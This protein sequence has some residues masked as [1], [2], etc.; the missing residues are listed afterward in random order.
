MEKIKVLLKGPLLTQSG[1]GAHARMLFSALVDDPMFDLFCENTRWGH[2]SFVTDITKQIEGVNQCIMKREMQKQQA[3]KFVYDLFVHV[4]IP[5]EFEKLGK[6]NVGVT[7]AVETDRISHQWVEKSNE[8]DLVIVPSEHSKHVMVSTMIDWMNKQTGEKGTFKINKPVVVCPEGVDENVFK[9]VE[10]DEYENLL[11]L[12]F[13][14]E[15]NFLHVGQWGNGGFGED[16]KNISNLVKYFIETFAGRKDVG[17]VLKTN[18]ARN[19]PQDKEI[20]V[21]RLKQIKSLFPPAVVPPIYLVHGSLT[22]EEMASLYT[23][24]Q[25]KAY[26]SLAAGEGFGIPTLEAAMCG[27][28]VIATNWSGHL[29]FMNK[30]KFSAVKYELKEIPEIAVWDPVL[31]KGSRW[32]VVDEADA[33]HRLKMMASKYYNPKQWAK[34]LRE[35]IKDTFSLTAIKNVF[36]DTVKHYAINQNTSLDPI[37]WMDSFIDTPDDFN[38]LFTMPR[39]HGDVFVATA[40]LDGLMTEVPENTKIYFATDPKYF[41]ILEDNPHIHKVVQYQPFMIMTEATEEVFDL[42]LTPDVAT[43]Y[44]FSNWVRRGQGRNLAEEYANHCGCKVGNYSIK[45]DVSLVPSGK[46]YITIHAGSGEG[47]WSAR[48]Y[49][50]WPE[51]LSNLSAFYEDITVVQVGAADDMKLEGVLDLRGKTDVHQLAG[52]IKNAKLHLGIDSFPMHLAAG[53]DVPVV[54]LFGSSYANSTGPY[55][56]DKENS[57]FI[58]LETEN[59]MGCQKAC[60]K[61]E[62]KV[63]KEQSCLNNIDPHEVFQ[64]VTAIL[65]RE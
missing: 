1:Y 41:P 8:M 16:R 32:A 9:P 31:I 46:E 37:E 35:N 57:R 11:N 47:Q 13:S 52:L 65:G 63:N 7:A 59:R 43:Q 58:L 15:F 34:E 61:N 19:T 23:H 17:L 21:N 26:V 27:L 22:E 28:P 36:L 33:K 5:Q 50:D 6:F 4:T 14:S 54:A 42:A 64:S 20:V 56:K 49:V 55:Y 53:F 40:V 18:M 62:C 24:P 44:N 25:I 51:V 30:G 45:I 48:K 60:Y 29:D 10:P 2:C 39:S 3:P 12:N 38:V